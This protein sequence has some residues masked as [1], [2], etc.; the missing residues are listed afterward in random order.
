[1]LNSQGGSID[2]NSVGT[3][4]PTDN[5]ANAALS[6]FMFALY[7]ACL[8]T[9]LVFPV[10]TQKEVG[11]TL[12]ILPAACGLA[13]FACVGLIALQGARKN[14][15]R[16]AHGRA[17]RAL[18]ALCVALPV[19][20]YLMMSATAFQIQAPLWA[21][22]FAWAVWGVGQGI[23]FPLIGSVQS[24]LE[25]AP[26]NAKV[27]PSV[28][29]GAIAGASVFCALALFAPNPLRA[30]LPFAYF[31]ITC[32]LVVCA[33]VRTAPLRGGAG[34][35]DDEPAPEEASPKMLS[36]LVVNGTFGILLCYSISHYEMA[37]TLAITAVG[38]ALGGA[39]L[40]LSIATV[41][42]SVTNSLIE[43]CCFPVIAICFFLISALPDAARFIPTCAVSAVFFLYTAF[44]WSLLVS[45]ARKQNLH[46]TAMRHFAVGLFAP[47]LG[48]FVGWAIAAGY[49]LLGGDL[50]N[51]GL[52]MFGWTVVYI[53]VLCIAPYAA[54]TMF[55]VDLLSESEMP[56]ETK[57]LDRS[58]NSWE[59]ARETIAARGALS[60]REKEVF[61][62]L[63]HGR[64]VEYVSRELVI[65]GNTAKTHKYRIYRKL[66]IG[67]HQE[68][69]D[70]VEEAEKDVLR[71]K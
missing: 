38:A 45:L 63:A 30:F 20:L 34:Q 11:A 7:C 64:N 48:F 28:I 58:N 57:P 66:G 29:S 3:K 43:R 37:P 1:M 17:P 21:Q 8:I 40:L 35:A 61:M 51:P 6:F 71:S 5:I 56:R 39:L 67:T 60:P 46:T 14:T 36:P 26:G 31:I 15:Q 4:S 47:A 10:A 44:H 18:F 49:A 23:V 32:M 62:M 54:N 55:E 59:Q 41:H 68:L 22:A 69:L 50:S 16:K 9:T 52:L 42:R 65:S 27:D 70:L 53:I 24:Q 33:L 12:T 13:T 19:P 2:S 25:I